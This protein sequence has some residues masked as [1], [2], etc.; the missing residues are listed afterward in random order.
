MLSPSKMSKNSSDVASFLDDKSL[1]RTT[2]ENQVKSNW[3]WRQVT[4]SFSDAKD[5]SFDERGNN[6]FRETI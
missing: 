3:S 5:G 4:S 1:F 2:V 6:T